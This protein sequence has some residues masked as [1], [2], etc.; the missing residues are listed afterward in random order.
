MFEVRYSD[1]YWDV[2]ADE[3]D[4]LADA[5]SCLNRLFGDGYRDVRIIRR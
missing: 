1:D 3:Y 2:F 5:I 4:N